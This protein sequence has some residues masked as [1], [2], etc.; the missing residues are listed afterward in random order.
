MSK[1]QRGNVKADANCT[2]VKRGT[3][4]KA[5]LLFSVAYTL[6]Q[7]TPQARLQAEQLAGHPSQLASWI[8][9]G[10]AWRGGQC[11]ATSWH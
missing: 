3:R 5:R 1:H 9:A 8:L 11:T 7:A 2:A 6:L 10:R 4:S